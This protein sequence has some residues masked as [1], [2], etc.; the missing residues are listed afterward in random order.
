MTKYYCEYCNIYLTHSSPGGRKQHV[1]GRKHISNKVEY[2]TV[3]LLEQ[4]AMAAAGAVQHAYNPA[5]YL[6]Q[7]YIANNISQGLYLPPN[8]MP[9]PSYNPYS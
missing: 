9:L 2:F 5:F 6:Q 8:F 7:Q 4:Q 3:F 1:R